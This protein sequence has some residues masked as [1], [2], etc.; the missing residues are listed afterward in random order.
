MIEPTLNYLPCPDA[1]GGHNMAYWQWGDGQSSHVVVC[2]HGLS[3]QG[4]DF[5]VLARALVGRSNGSLQVVCP[6][7]AGRG[8]SDWLKDAN[9]YQFPTY[10]ADMSCL[11]SH[12]HERSAIKTLDWVGTSMGGLIGLGLCGHPELPLPAPVRRLVLND[13]GPVVQWAVSYTHLTL[14]TSDLV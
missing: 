2:V 7:V 12:L 4:R 8:R 9:A 11:L 5:D 14:P 6:D 10:V 13:V 3:R 1:S